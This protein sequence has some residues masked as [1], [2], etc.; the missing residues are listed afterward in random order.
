MHYK[1]CSDS[2]RIGYVLK[3]YPRFSETFV[4]NEILAHEA[5]GL[6]IE[7]GKSS[8]I[9]SDVSCRVVDIEQNID[10][11]RRQ[12]VPKRGKMRLPCSTPHQVRTHGDAVER[13]QA[14]EGCRD[15]GNAELGMCADD[16]CAFRARILVQFLRE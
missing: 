13:K 3:R 1:R 11:Q 7:I 16:Q 4:V 15:R 2:P 12:P 9:D 6:D 14:F 10:P 8:R 5:A